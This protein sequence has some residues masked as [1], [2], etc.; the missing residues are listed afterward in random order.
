MHAVNRSKIQVLDLLKDH[1]PSLYFCIILIPKTTNMNTKNFT[2]SLKS[3]RQLFTD[4]LIILLG[5]FVF[6]MNT[7]KLFAQNAPADLTAY[8]ENPVNVNHDDASAN[9]L[10]YGD[11]KTEPGKGENNVTFSNNG[12]YY[13]NS[14]KNNSGPNFT[15]HYLLPL[16]LK[17]VNLINDI[18]ANINSQQVDPFLYTRQYE[19]VYN[20]F[21]PELFNKLDAT[22]KYELYTLY[23]SQQDFYMCDRFFNDWNYG[24]VIK[25]NEWKIKLRFNK[26]GELV[27]A[28]KKGKSKS[29]DENTSLNM[30]DQEFISD[31][32]VFCYYQ[33]SEKKAK[34]SGKNSKIKRSL[35]ELA[36]EANDLYIALH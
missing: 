9:L 15:V 32:A 18:S 12:Y 7:N 5:L 20:I 2:F 28:T 27:K 19:V 16:N 29:N 36:T 31:E 34:V 3:A 33:K 13:I 8:N 22:Y 17:P 6:F 23:N 21:N 11:I 35:H 14:E 1:I 25:T 26:N 4:L 24:T 30:S 10:T